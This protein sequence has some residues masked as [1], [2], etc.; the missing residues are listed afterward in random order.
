MNERKEERG[1]NWLDKKLRETSTRGLNVKGR[2]RNNEKKI[3][4]ERL[5]QKRRIAYRLTPCK[6]GRWKGSTHDNMCKTG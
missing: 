6:L 2:V 3:E 5:K 1:G 4:W